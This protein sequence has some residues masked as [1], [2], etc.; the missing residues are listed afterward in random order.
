MIHPRSVS[1]MRAIAALAVALYLLTLPAPVSAGG[2][3]TRYVSPDGIDAGSCSSLAAACQTITYALSQSIAG[4]TL[5][6]DRGVY[7][8]HLLIDKGI[9]ILQ[10]SAI[11][12]PYVIIISLH[13]L[14]TIHIPCATIDGGHNGRVIDIATYSGQVSL[15]KLTI[16]N[17]QVTDD[18]GA[19]IRNNGILILD[20][21]TLHDNSIIVSDLSNPLNYNYRGGAIDNQHELTLRGSSIHDNSAYGG[22]G[23]SSTGSLKVQNTEIYANNALS[24]GGGILVPYG[25]PS[26]LENTTLWGN[27]AVGGGGGVFVGTDH[28]LGNMGNTQIF[29]NVTISGNTSSSFGA[30]LVSHLRVDID[31]STLAL[32]SSPGSGPD[33]YLFESQFDPGYPHSQVADTIISDLSASESIC[34]VLGAENFNLSA[35]GNLSSDHSCDFTQPGDQVDTNPGLLPL[36]DN[37]GHV[38]THALPF[39]SPAIDHAGAYALGADA[40]GVFPQDGDLNGSIMPDVG[41]YEYAPHHIY[42]PDVK[43]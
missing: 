30:G 21:V 25:S 31:H 27:Y 3:N 22:G 33:L 4:D 38:Q 13:P 19:G 12:C 28:S 34:V 1:P 29:R 11:S 42:L 20:N 17:G 18:S 36:A 37:G 32:N 43:R 39:G 16:R 2:Q 23:I 10:N 7:T 5:L 6:L 40:R 8:E 9:R 14:I 35:G 15:E 24:Y 41:A 26:T